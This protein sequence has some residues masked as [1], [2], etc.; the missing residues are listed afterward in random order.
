MVSLKSFDSSIESTLRI[1][2]PLLISLSPP[3]SLSFITSL[4]PFHL[5]KYLLPL[6]PFFSTQDLAQ[7]YLMKENISCIRRVRK[8]DNNRI[9][10]ACGATVVN[11]AED[12]REEHVG[13]NC[14]LFEIR[15]IGD[16]LSFFF[17]FSPSFPLGMLKK[18][19]LSNHIPLPPLFFLSRA[20]FFPSQQVLYLP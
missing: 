17:T 2:N 19:P 5:K 13:T 6:P 8:T 12:L 18:S 10:R 11:R 4:F 7:H 20:F 14:G 3:L 9:A 1:P 16:E 15:K